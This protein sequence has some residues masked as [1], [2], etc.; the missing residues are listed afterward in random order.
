MLFR[1]LLTTGIIPQVEY[2]TLIDYIFGLCY[3]QIFFVMAEVMI[4]HRLFQK[5]IHSAKTV[6]EAEKNI[7]LLRKRK[8][9]EEQAAKA[10]NQTVNPIGGPQPS[11][12][13]PLPGADDPKNAAREEHAVTI[14]QLDVED[15]LSE[16]NLEDL[17]KWEEYQK[18][19]LPKN[20]GRTCFNYH[21]N[22]K[23]ASLR[24]QGFTRV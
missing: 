9:L 8:A 1:S 18:K 23:S 4:T 10:K 19:K 17:R 16:R 15:T 21:W 5:W 20:E 11:F 13:M 14:A 6:E 22:F 7:T 24:I 12:S 3:L 2:L